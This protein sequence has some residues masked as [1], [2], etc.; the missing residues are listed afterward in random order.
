MD[1]FNAIPQLMAST[2][3]SCASLD[4]GDVHDARTGQ[5]EP[6]RSSSTRPPARTMRTGASVTASNAAASRR[7]RCTLANS[8]HRRRS[9]SGSSRRPTP[10][11]SRASW[12]FTG[13]DDAAP[14]VSS[15]SGRVSSFVRAAT[16]AVRASSTV[17]GGRARPSKYG[18]SR[19]LGDRPSARPT[20]AYSLR[21]RG[22]ML[23]MPKFRAHRRSRR[24][25]LR[26]IASPRPLLALLCASTAVAAQCEHFTPFGHR[27][28]PELGSTSVGES[29]DAE[30]D[31]VR[32]SCRRRS[33][34]A[35]NRV[36][37]RGKV[38]D[39][40]ASSSHRRRPI[41]STTA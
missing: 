14:P 3:A 15:E 28:A 5:G 13:V 27:R 11:V 34:V 8:L 40:V 12:P 19:V 37:V 9:Q 26:C 1:R 22:D 31:F 10:P 6:A 25:S 18:S 23:K 36:R 7:R 21:R 17:S 30:V 4:G 24:S 2:C 33:P 20:F 35:V 38:S 41:S 29:A 16:C 32:L 39:S